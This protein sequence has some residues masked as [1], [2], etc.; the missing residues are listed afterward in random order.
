MPRSDIFKKEFSAI[1]NLFHK[2]YFQVSDGI[3]H[4]YPS[5]FS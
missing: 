2:V 1:K 4:M 5:A 3:F